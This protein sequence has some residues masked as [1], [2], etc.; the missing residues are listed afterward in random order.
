MSD[1]S[2]K[3]EILFLIGGNFP[4]PDEIPQQPSGDSESIKD[5]Q[6]SAMAHW[7]HEAVHVND[8]RHRD[9]MRDRIC[10]LLLFGGHL[11]VAEKAWLI[12]LL[13]NI[14]D[15]DIPREAKKGPPVKGDE[16]IEFM[17]D[18]VGFVL[19]DES[20]HPNSTVDERFERAAEKLPASKQKVR[21]MYYSDEFKRYMEN[22][23]RRW[24]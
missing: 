14:D 9:A 11:T 18:V 3:D 2:E 20:E 15:K 10:A 22:A 1:K 17:L 21:A 6:K 7:A 23:R 8:R 24:E 4:K 19:S 5:W 12:Y 16:R 13:R